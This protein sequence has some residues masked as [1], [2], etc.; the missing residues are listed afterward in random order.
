MLFNPGIPGIPPVPV[1]QYPPH[2]RIRIGSWNIRRHIVLK[3]WIIF[4]GLLVRFKKLA[5]VICESKC[6]IV[7]L[8]ELPIVFKTTNEFISIGAEKHSSRTY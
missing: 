7:A 1:K 6:D 4:V 3:R 8:Q 5:H 2:Q